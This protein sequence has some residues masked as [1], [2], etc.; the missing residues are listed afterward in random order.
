MIFI[1]DVEKFIYSSPINDDEIISKRKIINVIYK[2][3]SNKA[4]SINEIR[5]KN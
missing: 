4:S 5:V 3:I 2:M 1:N